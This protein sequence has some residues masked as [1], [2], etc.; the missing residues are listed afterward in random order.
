MQD[1]SNVNLSY[2]YV[3]DDLDVSSHKKKVIRLS[4]RGFCVAVVADERKTKQLLQYTF[5]SDNLSIESKLEAIVEINQK[6]VKCESNVFSIYTQ[7]NTQIPDEFYDKENDKAILPLMVDNPQKY[8]PLVE[9][10]EAWKLYNVSALDNELYFGLSKRFP[11]CKLT[12]VLSSLLKIVARDKQ[13]KNVLI[14]VEDSNFTIIAVDRH[15]LLGTNTFVFANEAD[16]VYYTHSFLRK[17]YV[18]PTDL[19]LK[20][21]G[22]IAPKSPI[23]NVLNKYYA[24]VE[25][26][27]ISGEMGENYSYFCDIFE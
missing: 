14:F 19:S 7:F 3:D 26:L 15:K 5:T 13:D 18:N 17:M 25:M 6:I 21:C 1:K 9:C 4:S 2:S 12:T 22:N 8:N 24:S 11:N 20:L 16:F 10:V 27:S 23:Y